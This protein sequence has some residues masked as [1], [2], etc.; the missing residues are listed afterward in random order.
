MK[1]K[2]SNR[3]YAKREESRTSITNNTTKKS[4]PRKAYVAASTKATQAKKLKAA[5]QQSANEE[6]EILLGYEND[7]KLTIPLLVFTFQ[8]RL[9]QLGG[10]HETSSWSH[11]KRI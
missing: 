6:A 1:Y 11:I 4:S 10:Y 9:L 7:P 2:I 5:E 8:Q 3:S